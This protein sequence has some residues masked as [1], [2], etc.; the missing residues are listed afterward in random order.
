MLAPSSTFRLLTSRTLTQTLAWACVALSSA[1][2]A[3]PNLDSP[4]TSLAASVPYMPSWLARHHLQLLADGAGLPLPVSH[5]PLPAAAVQQ[6]LDSLPADTPLAASR[7]AV[8]QEL[9]SLRTR[10][11]ASLHL[12]SESEAP[13][14]YGDNYTPG[15]S[16]SLSTPEGRWA[17]GGLSFAGRLGAKI[18][19][20]PNSLPE[21]PPGLTPQSQHTLRPDNSAAVVS[22]QGW[23]LQVSSQRYFWGP[24]WQNSLVNGSNNPAWTGAGLQRASAAPSNSPWLAWMGPWNFDVFV[25]KAQDP[26]V[27]SQQPSGFLFSGIRLTLKPQP[28]LELGLSRG[29]Q[30]GGA[31]RPGGVGEFVK[32]F[33]GQQTNKDVGDSFQDSSG[34]IAGYDVRVNCPKAWGRC[35]AYTQWMGED[36][37]GSTL[38]LPYKFM[39]LWGLE[40]TTADGQHRLFAE[41]LDTN[42]YSLP[43]DTRPTFPGYVNGVYRQG[44]T[45]GARWA[46]S[47]FGSGAQVLTLG[48]LDAANRRMLKLHTGTLVSALGAYNPGVDAPRGRL[49][50]VG[51]SQSLRMMG[52]NL[53]PELAYTQLRDGQDQASSKLHNLRVGLTLALPLMFQ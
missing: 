22:W 5:W 17:H 40:T 38:P 20:N 39:S 25:A 49:W 31:G 28:W 8:R 53:T 27:V 32:A 7:D 29:M 14:G 11:Q 18:E 6:A 2:A 50:G 34:Q 30:T 35:A 47:S 4:E 12:R 46:A 9:Q 23:N 48:W 37:A 13:V 21:Q 42:A 33:F 24:G 41:W 19:A 10:G 3:T 15:S 44:Y 45:Q 51:V 52:M 36:A 26:T 1:Q 43:W 16:A